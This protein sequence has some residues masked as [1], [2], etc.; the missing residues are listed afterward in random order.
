MTCELTGLAVASPGAVYRPHIDGAWPASALRE[1][2]AAEGG[3]V[4]REYMYDGYGDRRS[5]LT[6]LLYLNDDFAGG[7]TTFFLP[8]AEVG[9]VEARGVSPRAGSVLCFP[10]GDGAG[11]LV[12]EGSAVYSGCKYIVRTDVLY[13]VSPSNKAGGREESQLPQD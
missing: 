13:S 6:F 11:S 10:H 12:H 7:D 3:E 5:R 9:V 4:S 8:G 2:T 1:V